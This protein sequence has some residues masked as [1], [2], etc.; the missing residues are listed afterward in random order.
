MSAAEEFRS[1]VAALATRLDDARGCV[2]VADDGTM[3]AHVAGMGDGGDVVCVEAPDFVAALDELR[4][5]AD[6]TAARIEAL[7]E[8]AEMLHRTAH[9]GDRSM[10]MCPY[11]PCNRLRRYTPNARGVVPV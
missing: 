1:D 7:T 9:G 5:V 8:A 6:E 10:A 2:H 4:C 11:T 3:T